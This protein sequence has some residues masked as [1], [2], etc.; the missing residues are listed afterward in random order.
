MPKFS[1]YNASIY[2]NK[3]LITGAIAYIEM[4]EIGSILNQPSYFEAN[5][6]DIS[7]NRA[8]IGLAGLLYVN[9]RLIN[10]KFD[11]SNFD[12]NY[13]I[14]YRNDSTMIARAGHFFI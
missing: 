14:N 11:F 9:H 5:H 8:H 4:L 7:G 10:I 12:G 6:V 1:F 13:L 2:Q 3:A